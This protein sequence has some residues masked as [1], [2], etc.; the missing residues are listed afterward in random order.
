MPAIYI[1]IYIYIYIHKHTHTRAHSLSLSHTHKH[2]HTHTY[3]LYI[4]IYIYIKVHQ[5]LYRPVQALRVPGRSGSQISSQCIW[6]VSW[7][8]IG[9]LRNVVAVPKLSSDKCHY[10]DLMYFLAQYYA[11]LG[12]FMWSR[13]SRSRAK[14]L[15]CCQQLMWMNLL[16]F[17]CEG[18]KGGGRGWGELLA[19]R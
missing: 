10:S 7:S 11:A 4:Y 3:I 8:S 6:Y 9:S 17:I 14:F 13:T 15:F 16:H 18:C 2:T 19:A 5:S 12:C 1:Y